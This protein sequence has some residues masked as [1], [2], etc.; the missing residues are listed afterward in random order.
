MPVTKSSFF[1]FYTVKID[2][3]F[4]RTWYDVGMEE[5]RGDPNTKNWETGGRKST[6][7]FIAEL[8]SWNEIRILCN[9]EVKSNIMI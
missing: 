5:I 4:Y 3:T 9:I 8:F 2:S 1:R 6:N 7:Y